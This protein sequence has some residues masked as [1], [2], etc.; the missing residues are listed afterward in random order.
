VRWLVLACTISSF[1]GHCAARSARTSF[2]VVSAFFSDHGAALYYRLIEVSPD[3]P[4]SLVRYSRVASVNIYC[5]RM[6]VQSA[7]ARLRNTS[8]AG[9][10]QDNDPCAVKPATLRSRLSKYHRRLSYLEAF[11]F[12]VVAHC[13]S[14]SVLLELPTTEGLDFDA[15][16]TAHP[17]TA[18][19]WDLPQQI[20]RPAFGANDIFHNRSDA[21]DLALQKAGAKLVPELVSGRYDAGLAAALKGLGF[22]SRDAH[23][24]SILKDY[25]GPV[26]TAQA[27]AGFLPQLLNASSYQFSHYEAPT[28]PRLAMAAGIH[29]EV[30]LQVRV[31]PATGAVID[32]SALSG[33]PLLRPSALEATKKWRFASGSTT[34]PLHLTIDYE[35]H[36]P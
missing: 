19:L 9:L 5:P 3:G 6:V 36:C 27:S 16:K 13:G 11:S 24:R 26:S 32:A 31:D 1:I 22:K 14:R 35:L 4:D 17:E 2:Y 8:P 12:A 21:D 10:L 25:R 7:E 15:L 34:G 23:F 33:H 29:G 18:R 20:I 30:G 28:Y